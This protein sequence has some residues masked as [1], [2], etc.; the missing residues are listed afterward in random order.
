LASFGL[1]G[2]KKNNFS[3]E[4]HTE[5][6]LC[7][8]FPPF[9]RLYSFRFSV[10]HTQYAAVVFSLSWKYIHFQLSMTCVSLEQYLLESEMFGGGGG[11]G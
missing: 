7:F 2:E 11:G 4:F 1:P 9:F 5:S 10:F 8:S 3:S 6:T